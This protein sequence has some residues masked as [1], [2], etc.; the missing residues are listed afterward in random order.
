MAY[1]KFKAITEKGHKIEDF[2]EAENEIQVLK[3]LKSKNLYPVAL[4][5]EISNKKDIWQYISKYRKIGYKEL[6]IFTQELALLIKSGIPILESLKILEKETR[7]PKFK[8]VISEIKD[9]IEKGLD[10]SVS[11]FKHP[12]VFPEL[13]CEMIKAGEQ[14]GIIS[15]ILDNLS[16]YYNEQNKIKNQILTALYYPLIVGILSVLILFYLVKNII[17]QFINM[18]ESSGGEIPLLTSLIIQLNNFFNNNFIHIFIF[19]VILFLVLVKMRKTYYFD[20]I[21]LNL[22]LINIYFKTI[23]LYRFIDTLALLLKNNQDLLTSLEIAKDVVGNKIYKEFFREARIKVEKGLTLSNSLYQ[24]HY[25]PDIVFRMI[26]IGEE[27]GRLPTVL[28][29][30]SRHYQKLIKTYL[31]KMI[32]LLE[33]IMIIVLAVIVGTLIISVMMPLFDIYSYL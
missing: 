2:I 14:A 29:Y 16:E 20:F 21:I 11:F 6:A 1:Y 31:K 18:I 3:I 19:T 5:K 15:R 32:S 17:P 7:N 9:D 30:L 8:K 22:P 12:G 10:M 27:S 13:Y 24:N 4:N 33:P 28:E 25:I 23:Y 26:K